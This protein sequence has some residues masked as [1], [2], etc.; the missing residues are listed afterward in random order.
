MKYAFILILVFTVACTQTNRVPKEEDFVVTVKAVDESLKSNEG[1]EIVAGLV[2]K[3]K[4]NI[5]ILHG[6]PLIHVQ[7]YDEQNKP[8]I[9]IFAIDQIG[10]YHNIQPDEFYNA[11][12]K[13]FNGGKRMIKVEKP[14]KYTLVA[15]ASFSIE[16]SGKE[17]KDFKVLSE[18]VE[19]IVE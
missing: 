6:S 14:G 12:I 8:L 3:S 2:N 18:P 19:I 10:I 13:S 7:I 15:T 11:D 17:R 5:K 1:I 9:S 16:L 4:N